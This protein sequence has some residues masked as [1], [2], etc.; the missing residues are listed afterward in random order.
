[1]KTRSQAVSEKKPSAAERTKPMFDEEA[2]APTSLKCEACEEVSKVSDLEKRDDGSYECPHC[3]APMEVSEAKP[4][5]AAKK[6]APPVERE[7]GDDTD[8][9]EQ[10]MEEERKA[11]KKVEASKKETKSV[12]T[13]TGDY[14]GDCGAEWPAL[15]G[16]TQINCGH[17]KAVR[18]DDPRK[19]T[20]MRDVT[21]SGV[22]NPPAGPISKV[23]HP[24]QPQVAI[25]GR[26]ISLTW[27]E[28]TFPVAQYS[29][30]KVGNMIMSREVSEGEDPVDVARRMLA[31]LQKIAD[32][33]FDTQFAWYRKKLGLIEK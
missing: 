10:E 18:V 31:D 13:R 29:S 3:A 17:T 2:L 8:I 32:V 11:A 12:E 28:A 14:C 9:I 15:L 30:M 1:M 25:S 19:A 26:R 23:D 22:T 24:N 33:A 4:A 7:P 27:G 20:R 5:K 16:K 21:A 6:P